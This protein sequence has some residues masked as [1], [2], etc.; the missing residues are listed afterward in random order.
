MQLERK[1][2]LRLGVRGVGWLA[3]AIAAGAVIFVVF[4]FAQSLID[5]KTEKPFAVTTAS[6]PADA[7]L[8]AIVERDFN[9]GVRPIL[10]QLIYNHT[11]RVAQYSDLLHYAAANGE[12]KLA[13]TLRFLGP[14]G[15]SPGYG[16]SV[17]WGDHSVCF[18]ED[19]GSSLGYFVGYYDGGVPPE[20]TAH[21][22]RALD[23]GTLA[24]GSGGGA[25]PILAVRTDLADFLDGA[26]PGALLSAA[27]STR[28]DELPEE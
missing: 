16:L 25:R 22:S 15:D 17:K 8:D 3:L 6:Y 19:R 24:L 4:N 14:D 21:T 10:R 23:G 28:C 7:N 9:I 26:D 18:T 11:Y 20:L 1:R 5:I 13:D 12:E 2:L 27:S